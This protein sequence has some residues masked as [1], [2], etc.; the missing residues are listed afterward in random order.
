MTGVNIMVACTGVGRKQNKSFERM[1][2]YI[3]L[4]RDYN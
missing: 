2:S 4:T 3:S 1:S